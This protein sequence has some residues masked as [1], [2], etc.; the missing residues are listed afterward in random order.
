MLYEGQAC[1][2]DTA[3]ARLCIRISNATG[4]RTALCNLEIHDTGPS[5]IM[6]CK[7]IT[8]RIGVAV[9]IHGSQEVSIYILS[10]CCHLAS[11][12]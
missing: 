7:L 1:T 9:F 10:V 11:I 6:I 4:Q 5:V 8:D 12:S 2:I 3:G